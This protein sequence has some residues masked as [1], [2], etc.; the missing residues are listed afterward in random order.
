MRPPAVAH[1]KV[2][3]KYSSPNGHAFYGLRSTVLDR[4]AEMFDSAVTGI[5]NQI[6]IFWLT[7]KMSKSFENIIKTSYFF[8]VNQFGH[9]RCRHRLGMGWTNVHPAGK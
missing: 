8:S 3:K 4:W 5:F 7:E 6:Q 1:D 2:I 9:K